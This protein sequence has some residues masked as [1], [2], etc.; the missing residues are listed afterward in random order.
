MAVKR[1]RYNLY[2]NR[3]ES[4]AKSL[5]KVNKSIR[6]DM[7]EVKKLIKKGSADDIFRYLCDAN[8][9]MF[10]SIDSLVVIEELNWE[11]SGRNV[12]F[13]ESSDLVG[14]LLDARFD[15]EKFG[16]L[17]FPMNSFVLAMPE[18]YRYKGVLM[19]GIMVNV[20]KYGD[21]DAMYKQYCRFM[22]KPEDAIRPLFENPDASPDD[23]FVSLMHI[24]NGGRVETTSTIRIMEKPD[25]LMLALKANSAQ[26]FRQII[27]Q[28]SN[29][30]ALRSLPTDLADAEMQFYSLKLVSALCVYN[31]ATSGDMLTY[32][33][34]QQNIQTQ[35]KLR[36][37]GKN[38]TLRSH[39]QSNQ[40]SRSMHIR[41]WH[42]RQLKH[43][44]YYQGEYKKYSPGSRWVFV[45]DALIEGKGADPYT[46]N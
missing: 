12:I 42:F 10:Y 32:G 11:S 1:L 6:S 29:Q 16:G 21:L 26:E 3:R 44:R 41:N 35:I 40:R 37:D 43:S 46:L 45:R 4:L 24:D 18:G 23:V 20:F 13:P 17:T 22:K 33:L 36:G 28:Y 8:L 5:R 30:E 34:P 19:K 15:V 39:V 31:V 38:H 7:P 9:D 2:Q 27:G 25:K 14:S